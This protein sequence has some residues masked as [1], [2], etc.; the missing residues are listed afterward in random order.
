VVTLERS[1]FCLTLPRTAIESILPP[2]QSVAEFAALPLAAQRVRILA[3]G[4]LTR[5]PY[6]YGGAKASYLAPRFMARF[7]PGNPAVLNF[8]DDENLISLPYCKHTAVFIYDT[9]AGLNQATNDGVPDHFIYPV[10][11]PDAPY[12]VSLCYS[13]ESRNPALPLI[14]RTLVD[15]AKQRRAPQPKEFFATLNDI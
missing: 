10:D 3:S 13:S 6:V 12:T 7:A 5:L 9:L 14:V 11:T 15:L 4:L 2:E 8:G 1:Y